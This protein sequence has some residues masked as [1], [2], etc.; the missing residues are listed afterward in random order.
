MRAEGASGVRTRT[1]AGEARRVV[2]RRHARGRQAPRP[3]D[4]RPNL[5][6]EEEERERARDSAQL[7][8]APARPPEHRR[9]RQHERG[10]DC[11]Q[12]EPQRARGRRGRA[13]LEGRQHR[14]G[15]PDV[16]HLV[17]E[18]MP[19][20]WEDP[21][22]HAAHARPAGREEGRP[23]Q[24]EGAE[25]LRPRRTRGA[26]TS[27]SGAPSRPPMAAIA[28][29]ARGRGAARRARPTRTVAPSAATAAARARHVGRPRQT[30]SM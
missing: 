20:H 25:H 18:E 5:E 26:R 3:R 8:R 2:A 28:A 16:G 6:G 11:A 12:A 19:L 1:R 10:T 30:P 27:G 14:E 21:L 15:A 23:A 22:E 17:L 4:G 13:Q 7:K 9:A 24:R 29:G